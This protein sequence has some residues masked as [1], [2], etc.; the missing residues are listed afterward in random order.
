M[1]DLMSKLKQ[2]GQF[3][4]LKNKENRKPQTSRSPCAHCEKL[5]YTNRFRPENLCE[6]KDQNM[7]KQ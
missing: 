6:W 1:E 4:E 3:N 2:M 5:G 7:N